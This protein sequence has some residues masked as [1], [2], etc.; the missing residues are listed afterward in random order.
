MKVDV[1]R[2]TSRGPPLSLSGHRTLRG[3]RPL[4][5]E[6]RGFSQ[7]RLR[8]REIAQLRHGDASKRKCRRSPLVHDRTL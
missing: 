2:G 5:S 3:P 7:A 6:T 8:V 1:T 4:S